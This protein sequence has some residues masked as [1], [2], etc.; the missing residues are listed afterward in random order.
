MLEALLTRLSGLV[1]PLITKV[2]QLYRRRWG[3][4]LKVLRRTDY[5][6][7]WTLALPGLLTATT[8]ENVP[9]INPNEIHAWLKETH[10]AA[11]FGESE[12][13]LYFE[14]RTTAFITIDGVSAHIENRVTER[15]GALVKSPN[16][17]AVSAILL[18]IDLSSDPPGEPVE[19]H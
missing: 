13:R 1:L 9:G 12:I 19:V 4:A 2:P 3:E 10:D 15:M 7:V 16:A 17:G 14:S 8:L 5:C 18:G 11:D 6:S